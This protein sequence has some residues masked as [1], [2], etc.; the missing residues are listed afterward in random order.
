MGR[1]RRVLD[2]NGCLS[3]SRCGT[4]KYIDNFYIVDKTVTWYVVNGVPYGRPHPWCNACRK[5][6]L[7]SR[8]VPAGAR[9]V[10][11]DV[12]EFTLEALM[13]DPSFLSADPAERGVRLMALP[14]IEYAKFIEQ[15][16]PTT[17]P[18]D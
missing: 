17:D 4:K 6:Y 13:A 15:A 11:V 14:A 3:C 12:E 16:T 2:A 1:K 9:A 7:R 8:Y 10:H 18:M 5:G